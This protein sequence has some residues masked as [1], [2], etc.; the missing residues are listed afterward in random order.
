[1]KKLISKTIYN[2]KYRIN[3]FLPGGSYSSYKRGGI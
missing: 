2:P 3:R 1:M